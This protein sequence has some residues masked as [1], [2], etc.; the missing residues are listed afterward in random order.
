M[1][2]KG[3]SMMKKS[4]ILGLNVNIIYYR[5]LK[6]LINEYLGNDSLNRITFVGKDMLAM[7]REN[8]DYRNKL[9]END[10]VLLAN[11]DLVT[12]QEDAAPI[13]QNA[14]TNYNK[15]MEVLSSIRESKTVL[16][17]YEQEGDEEMI[18]RYIKRKMPR[19]RIIEQLCLDIEHSMESVI[20]SINAAVPDIII[21]T[22]KAPEQEEWIAKE[23]NKLNSKLFLGFGGITD[24]IKKSMKKD[25]LFIRV[26]KRMISYIKRIF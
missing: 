26:I 4:D 6:R 23:C 17:L 13:F 8:E 9:E 3:D 25:N 5:E 18:A 14:I 12:N 11:R 1:I 2:E 15:L 22:I 7:A 10:L 16:L 19:A 21:S 20:N 24:Q